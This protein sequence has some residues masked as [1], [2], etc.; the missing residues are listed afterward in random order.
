[1]INYLGGKALVGPPVCWDI[2]QK[3]PQW[4]LYFP[5]GLRVKDNANNNQAIMN[6]KR[7]ITNVVAREE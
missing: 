3:I 6:N 7:R 5:G 2:S 4:I 1:M